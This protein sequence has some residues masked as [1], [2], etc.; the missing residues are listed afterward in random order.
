MKITFTPGLSKQKDEENETTIEKYQRKTREKRKKRKQEQNEKVQTK[1]GTRRTAEDKSDEF[2]NFGDDGEDK[3]E[4]EIERKISDVKRV[5]KEKGSRVHPRTLPP[6]KES[7]ADELVL[8]TAS[9]NLDGQEPKHFNMKAVLK[10]EKRR[11]KMGRKGKRDQEEGELQEDF[12][13]NVNDER[14]NVLHEDHQFAIDPTNPQCVITELCH[15]LR[16]L[17][18]PII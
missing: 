15:S 13:V 16:T 2:F 17:I 14:F 8:L 12:K 4:E 3:S 1:E 9:D 7:T 5:W 6:R 18:N 10:A 11:G